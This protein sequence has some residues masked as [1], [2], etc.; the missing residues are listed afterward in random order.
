[1]DSLKSL[2][3]RLVLLKSP[4]TW[5]GV[6]VVTPPVR[7]LICFLLGVLFGLFFL[8]FPYVTIYSVLLCLRSFVLPCIS[9]GRYLVIQHK[10][11]I[12]FQCEEKRLFLVGWCF[13]GFL[14]FFVNDCR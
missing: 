4:N 2:C 9:G 3:T 12:S 1:M 14:V 11:E 10:R 7:G 13:F 6:S 8:S 5:P